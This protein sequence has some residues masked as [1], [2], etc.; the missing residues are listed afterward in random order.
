MVWILSLP[1][2][3]LA[4]MGQADIPAH[5]EGQN[6]STVGFELDIEH[7]E[8]PDGG[9]SDFFFLS[10]V[11]VGPWA[12]SLESPITFQITWMRLELVGAYSDPSRN[13]V[14]LLITQISDISSESKRGDSQSAGSDRNS[15]QLRVRKMETA[16]PRS[17]YTPTHHT[18][19]GRLK[20]VYNPVSI[21]NLSICHSNYHF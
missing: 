8:K 14:I 6:I 3:T 9:F 15:I 21:P 5:I 16:V 11:V 10:W 7:A 20:R 17:T 18:V 2:M 1:C 19:R 12:S 4:Y 13:M